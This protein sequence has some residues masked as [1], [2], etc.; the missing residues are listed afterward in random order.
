MFIEPEILEWVVESAGWTVA[1]C[2]SFDDAQAVANRYPRAHI[3]NS[4]SGVHYYRHE[5]VVIE[6]AVGEE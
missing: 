6:Y 3:R 4:V 2:K 5:K 1:R